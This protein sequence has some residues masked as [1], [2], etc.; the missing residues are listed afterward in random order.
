VSSAHEE[1]FGAVLGQRKQRPTALAEV[2]GTELNGGHRLHL[3]L[4]ALPRSQAKS[5]E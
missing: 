5:R 3:T 4:Y 1:R 2:A